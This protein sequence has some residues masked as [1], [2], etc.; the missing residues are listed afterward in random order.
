MGRMHAGAAGVNTLEPPAVRG[1]PPEAYAGGAGVNT[2]RPPATRRPQ[3]PGVA[4]P[5]HPPAATSEYRPPMRAR[6]VV[7]TPA[8][9]SEYRPPSRARTVKEATSTGAECRLRVR[10]MPPPSRT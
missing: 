9:T 4:E 5:W 3:V 6:A 2:Q 7:G 8:A 1:P 10:C